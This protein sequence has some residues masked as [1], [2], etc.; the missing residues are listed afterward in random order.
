MGDVADFPDERSAASLRVS[1][2]PRGAINLTPST[3]KLRPSPGCRPRG[4]A[5]SVSLN[6]LATQGA[7]C[8]AAVSLAPSETPSDARSEKYSAQKPRVIKRREDVC[9]SYNLVSSKPMFYCLYSVPSI[10]PTS[11]RGIFF[12]FTKISGVVPVFVDTSCASTSL[13]IIPRAPDCLMNNSICASMDT[14]SAALPP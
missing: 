5:N 14:T 2:A 3:V 12:F 1:R 13:V 10:R 9:T 7:N 11:L 8:H 6:I 4:G